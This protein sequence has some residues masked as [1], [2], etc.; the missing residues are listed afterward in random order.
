MR[1]LVELLMGCCSLNYPTVVPAICSQCQ[2]K[3][4]A[5]LH[6]H[7]SLD[8]GT[9]E[10]FSPTKTPS[11]LCPWKTFTDSQKTLRKPESGEFE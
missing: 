1:T 7:G 6:L 2:K 5:A 11:A 4:E 9:S 8:E 3:E 10:R